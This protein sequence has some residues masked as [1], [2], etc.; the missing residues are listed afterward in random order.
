MG[1]PKPKVDFEKKGAE[2]VALF[3]RKLGALELHVGIVGPAANELE[4]GSEKT[5]ADLGA[6]HEFGSEVP[7]GKRGHIPERSFIRSTLAKRRGDIARLVAS[8]MRKILD[9]TRTPR[10]ALEA[11]GIKVSNWIKKEVMQ[12]EGIPPPLAAS[13]IARKGSSR[14]LVDHGQLIA[15]GVSYEI[16]KKGAR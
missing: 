3:L 12:G 5:L 11:I 4:E 16:T 1:S 10:A 14:P 13:T 15:H 2:D 8:E 7:P 9:G 6:L